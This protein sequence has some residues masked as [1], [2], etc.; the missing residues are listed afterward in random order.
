M[1]ESQSK[2]GYFGHNRTQSKLWYQQGVLR[3]RSHTL[4]RSCTISVVR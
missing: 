4:F 1:I 3:F 2:I